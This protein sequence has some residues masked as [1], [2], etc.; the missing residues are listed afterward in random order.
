MEAI[1]FANGLL[2]LGMWVRHGGLS[3][4]SSATADFTGLGQITALFGTYVAL[5]QIVLMS[6][7]PWLEQIF[8]VE[9]LISWHRWLGFTCLALILGHTAFT[10]IGYA[11]GD[12]CSVVAETW[13]MI[14]PIPTCSWPGWGW[15]CLFS[16]R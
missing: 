10:T 3:G 2:I 16:L 15:G 4:L 5:I 12:G 7:T 1:A 14:A 13:S 8:G 9:R 11:L 6:R